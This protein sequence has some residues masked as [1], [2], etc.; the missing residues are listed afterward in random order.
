MIQMAFRKITM[1]LVK[2]QKCYFSRDVHIPY[3]WANTSRTKSTAGDFF[4]GV[5][6][7]KVVTIGMRGYNALTV[8]QVI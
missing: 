6:D 3:M 1:A 7:S 4:V 8:K 5:L 2:R